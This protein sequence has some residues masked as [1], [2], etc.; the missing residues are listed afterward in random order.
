[1]SALGTEFKINVNAE[2]IEG[3]HMS[4]YDFECILYV[5][6]NRSVTFRKGDSTV[7]KTDDDNYRVIVNS[8][9]CIKL[10]RGEVKLRFIAHIP[11][12]DFKDGYRTE[13]VDGICTGETIT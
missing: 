2:P 9:D 12:A 4:D 3:F 5:Y 11:D 1:M 13:I 6:T 8:E 10:G 7:K